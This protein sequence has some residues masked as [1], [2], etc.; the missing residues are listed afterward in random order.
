MKATKKST[1][2]TKRSAG[3]FPPTDVDMLLGLPGRARGT[4][5]LVTKFE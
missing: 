5:D 4:C 3:K 2:G 1:F